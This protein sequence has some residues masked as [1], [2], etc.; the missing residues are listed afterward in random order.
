MMKLVN[1]ILFRHLEP[2]SSRPEAE[3][4]SGE[5]FPASENA[6]GVAK[7]SRLRAARFARDDVRGRMTRG[8]MAVLLAVALTSPAFAW[9][10]EVEKAPRDTTPSA[11]ADAVPQTDGA[12]A[13]AEGQADASPT[14]E[15]PDGIAEDNTVG[16][17]DGTAA[18]GGEGADGTGESEDPEEEAP[19]IDPNNQV[20]P[21]QMP[22][23]SFLYDTSIAELATADPYMNNQTVQVVGEAIG[24]VIAA[25][26]GPQ[27]VWV[28]LQEKVDND[29]PQISVIM[30]RTQADLIDRLGRYGVRGTTLQVRGTFHLT[31]PDHDGLTDLH[32]ESVTVVT[33]GTESMPELNV[34]Q[35]I[36]GAVL[37]VVAGVLLLIFRRLQE[38][39]R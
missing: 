29:Y 24:D 35:F 39:Q 32:A 6:A 16:A 14:G 8:A 34:N 22:D 10:D 36:P 7:I 12:D 20:N 30:T 31:C 3:G 2:S 19:Q 4:R 28:M 9:A 21:Q 38:G 23:S 5:I 26:D 15:V 37:F 11:A 17:D 13:A 18:D 25:G 1:A 33:R 27:F